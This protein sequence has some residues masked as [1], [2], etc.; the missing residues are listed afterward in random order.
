MHGS[1]SRLDEVKTRI[2]EYALFLTQE[3]QLEL[4]DLEIKFKGGDIV[5]QVLAD[6]PA[7]GI[8][9]DECSAFNKKIIQHIESEQFLTEGYEV[10]VSS[11]GLDRPLRTPRDYARMVNKELRI[12]LSQPVNGRWEFKGVLKSVH[13]QAIL[14]VCEGQDIVIPLANIRQGKQIF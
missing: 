14:L 8:T 13:E 6:R 4:I 12:L 9:I 2:S 5:I 7:G 11:P 3:A 10:E 1:A